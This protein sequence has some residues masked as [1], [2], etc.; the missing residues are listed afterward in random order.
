ML[1]ATK[2]SFVKNSYTEEP[3]KRLALPDRKRVGMTSSS[4]RPHALVGRKQIEILVE[5]SPAD[6]H[7]SE[8]E[9]AFAYVHK[10]GKYANVTME[11]RPVGLL[12]EFFTIGSQLQ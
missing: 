7:L 9:D 2:C 5:S 8:G 3:P 4:E 1:R 6:T 11:L 10:Q 12:P